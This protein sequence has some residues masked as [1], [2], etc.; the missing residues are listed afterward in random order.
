MHASQLIN[1]I[2]S[3][4]L[5]PLMKSHG[6]RKRA[7]RFWRDNGQVIDV[8]DL[9]KSQWNSFR[10]A[11]FTINLGLFWPAINAFS[12]DRIRVLPPHSY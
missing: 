12:A 10:H 4:Y 5:A 3:Q 7:Q 6:F 8:L 2:L 1:E 9:Q 11:Q